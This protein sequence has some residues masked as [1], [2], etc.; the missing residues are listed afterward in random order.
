MVVFSLKTGTIIDKFT[1]RDYTSSAFEFLRPVS[2]FGLSK[3]I[4]RILNICYGLS[5]SAVVL[6]FSVIPWERLPSLGILKSRAII[7]LKLK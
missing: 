6:R 7:I 2:G 5:K 3:A 1:K 4:T